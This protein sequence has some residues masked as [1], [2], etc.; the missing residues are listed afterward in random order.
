VSILRILRNL[1]LIHYPGK[2]QEK[3][4]PDMVESQNAHKAA[5]LPACPRASDL[6]ASLSD[7][8]TSL[9][10]EKSTSVKPLADSYKPFFVRV[11]HAPADSDLYAVRGEHGNWLDVAVKKGA[12]VHDPQGLQKIWR[13]GDINL[14][15]E[16]FENGSRVKSNFGI[17][18]RF[19]DRKTGKPLYTEAKIDPA[20]GLVVSEFGW[21][22]N[23]HW[24]VFRQFEAKFDPT[25]KLTSYRTAPGSEYHLFGP[26]KTHKCLD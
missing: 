11:L 15:N 22:L 3:E 4:E 9:L 7:E 12:D 13:A 17:G 20:S 8:L 1:K 6:P 5:E 19:N 21:L 16:V 25:G 14:Q 23:E 18:E 10:T 24:H 26:F 2:P